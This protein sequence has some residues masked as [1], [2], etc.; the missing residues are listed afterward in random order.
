MRRKGRM[1]AE[2][3]G[4]P[5]EMRNAARGGKAAQEMA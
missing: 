3:C 2:R 1:W 5:R 4:Y